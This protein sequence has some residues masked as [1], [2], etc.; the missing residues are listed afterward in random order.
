M[1]DDVGLRH[2]GE[3]VADKVDGLAGVSPLHRGYDGLGLSPV[4][5]G[6]PVHVQLLLDVERGVKKCLTTCM[7]G[8]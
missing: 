4:D 5:V 6:P 7:Q 8:W 1:D 2:E 3:H